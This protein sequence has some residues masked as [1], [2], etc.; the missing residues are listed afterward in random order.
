MFPARFPVLIVL[1]LTLWFFALACESTDNS[2]QTE[3]PSTVAAVS[4]AVE[5]SAA[6]EPTEPPPA[7]PSPTATPI[8]TATS[9]PTVTSVPTAT[10]TPSPTPVPTATPTPSPTP[11]PT[12]TPTPNP[13]PVPI[14]I[15]ISG[16]GTRSE[17]A[18]LSEGI[19][20]VHIRWSGNRRCERIAPWHDRFMGMTC[21]ERNFS[22]TMGS[23]SSNLTFLV[24]DVA[25]AWSGMRLVQVSEGIG[26][27]TPGY[28]TFSVQADYSADWEIIIESV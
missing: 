20:E 1:V 14:S 10:P 23:P 4:E 28:I 15:T 7:T 11:V 21:P 2:G 13:T 22:V 5:T 8:P 24:S 6:A 12:A 26:N 18:N 16:S 25:V 17:T 27:V 3:T 19:Y 9:T